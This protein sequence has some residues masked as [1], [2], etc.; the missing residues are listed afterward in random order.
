MRFC[1][2]MAF[3]DKGSTFRKRNLS[4]VVKNYL[5]TDDFDVII[6]EQYPSGFGESVAKQNPDRVKF[7]PCDKVNGDPQKVGRF[8][9][10]ELL[11]AAV[12]AYPDYDYYVMGDADALLSKEAFDSLREATRLLDSGEASIVFPFD[13]VLYLNEP[14]TKRIVANEPLLPGTK[15]HGAEIFRQTGHCNIFKKSTWDAVGGFDEA[16][17]NWGAEDDAFLTKCKRIVGHSQRLNG[18]IYPL[19]HPKVNTNA[20]CESND[21]VSNR[22]RCACVRRMTIDDL[23]LY[24]TGKA[25][26]DDLVAKYDALGRLSVRLR[27]K[28]TPLCLLT[29]DTT[30]YDIDNEGE[31][32]FTKLLDA[33]SAED[34]A[35]YIPTFINTA[36]G[37]LDGIPGLT[38]EQRTELKDYLSKCSS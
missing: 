6:T 37:G 25:K 1:V 10:T 38:A 3:F 29:I 28:C 22:K 32:S 2:L 11:N 31:M 36:L 16:F 20:Y 7:V 35:W 34:G 13:N 33:V 4:E 24:C 21:Y 30:I 14:D 9:K 26:L 8:C 23:T 5:T 17:T 12:K 27:W 18:T 15:D 19:F